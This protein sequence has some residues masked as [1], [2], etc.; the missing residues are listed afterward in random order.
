MRSYG[1]GVSSK[2]TIS[3]GQLAAPVGQTASHSVHQTQASGLMMTATLLTIARPWPVHTSTHRAHPLHFSVSILGTLDMAA[4][5]CLH[6]ILPSTAASIL[7]PI[8]HARVAF[9]MRSKGKFLSC[10]LHNASVEGKILP[11]GKGILSNWIGWRYL[12]PIL[13]NKG[14]KVWN[15]RLSCTMWSLPLPPLP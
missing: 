15:S 13:V 10:G 5:T 3:K 2:K 4:I 8:S 1:L 14:E 6:D 7:S 11:S 9:N 12:Q